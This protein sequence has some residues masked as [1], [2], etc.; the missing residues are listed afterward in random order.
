MSTQSCELPT[1]TERTSEP[2]PEGVT[3]TNE[4]VPDPSPVIVPQHRTPPDVNRA[5]ESWTPVDTAATPDDN[6]ITFTGVVLA[7]VVPFPSWP[8]ALSP[9]HR[10][11]P[12]VVTAHVWSKP[13]EIDMTV[14]AD[15]AGTPE[16]ATAPRKR[17]NR[18]TRAEADSSLRLIESS[19][20]RADPVSCEPNRGIMS[21][22]A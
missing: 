8:Y 3:G 14:A 21:R 9:Q 1:E 17:A 10:T 2:S 16:S 6:P 11:P 12:A 4:P 7:V 15:A 22:D 20:P 19:S 18:M 13:A 5:H